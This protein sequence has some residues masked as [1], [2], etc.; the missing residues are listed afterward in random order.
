MRW[1]ALVI[2][3]LLAFVCLAVLVDTY[4]LYVFEADAPT[5]VALAQAFAENVVTR[6]PV[7]IVQPP[8]FDGQYWIYAVGYLVAKAA[9]AFGLLDEARFPSSQ[10]LAVFAV[11]YV[12]L[13]AQVGSVALAFLTT[14]KLGRSTLL[15]LLL[16][17]VFVFDPQLLGIDLLRI[18]RVILFLFML[19][20]AFSLEVSRGRQQ[21]LLDVALGVSAAALVMT[22]ITAVVFLVVPAFAYWH[23]RI[24]LKAPS[25][26]VS[27]FLVSLVVASALIAIRYLIYGWHDPG[28]LARNLFGKLAEVASWGAVMSREPYLYYNWDVFLPLGGTFFAIFLLALAA[29][30]W[31]LVRRKDADAGLVLLPLAVLSLLGIPAFKHSR[32]GY[33]L[34]PLYLYVIAY[35]VWVL[36]DELT[37]LFPQ[38]RKGLWIVG[39]IIGAVLLFPLHHAWNAY[40]EARLEASGRAESIKLTRIAPREWFMK[41]VPAK[42]RV[43]IF[44]NSEWADPPI[45]DLGYDFSPDTVEVPVP[46]RRKNG[47]FLAPRPRYTPANC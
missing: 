22:K 38:G 13:L 8:Y 23:Q 16:S 36:R 20:F 37:R 42:T 30:V 15:A 27:T 10:S 40:Q 44:I 26:H 29:C 46:R 19:V 28:L 41:N 12:N 17:L 35:G 32:A 43:A 45:F 39:I 6:L 18:D 34:M 47:A 24:A 33:I 25:R 2:L 5:T 21:P 3:V 9:M 31:G 1:I 14:A 4:Y 11:R 7:P